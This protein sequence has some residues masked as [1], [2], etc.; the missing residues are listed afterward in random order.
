VR[1]SLHDPHRRPARERPEREEVGVVILRE[2][3]RQIVICR[4][5]FWTGQIDLADGSSKRVART[6]LTLGY[7]GQ[8]LWG[9]IKSLHVPYRHHG[10]I[11]GRP[12]GQRK[13]M[14]ES[15]L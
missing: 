10:G 2:M 14:K 1:K 6:S 9:E 7:S 12:T 11:G 13:V 15:G 3:Q 4:R 8:L 5:N